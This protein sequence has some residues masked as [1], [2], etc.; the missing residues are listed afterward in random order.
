VYRAVVLTT[1]VVLLLA[2]VGVAMA[3]SKGGESTVSTTSEDTSSGSTVAQDTTAPGGFS[4][5][6]TVIGEPTVDESAEPTVAEPVE[7]RPPPTSNTGKGSD[8]T[9]DVGEPAAGAPANGNG[10]GRPEQAGEP[11]GR[12][13]GAGQ[14][15]VTLCHKGK[16]TITVGE[17]AKEAHLRHGDGLG[18][19]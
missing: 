5:E 13:S 12:G 7:E 10:L 19:C 2:A 15:K 3:G 18:A 16:N 9:R 14:Q 17:P 6:P 4:S 11:E 1:F 8:R